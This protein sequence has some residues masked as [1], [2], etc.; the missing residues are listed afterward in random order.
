MRCNY[1]LQ[2]STRLKIDWSKIYRSDTQ[3]VLITNDSCITK[4]K[5]N[6]KKYF[7]RIITTNDLSVHNLFTLISNDIANNNINKDAIRISTID[8]FLVETTALLLDKFGIDGI[9]I[10]QSRSF[11][12]KICMKEKLS[13]TSIKIPK[14]HVFSFNEY[15]KRKNDYVDEIIQRVGFPCFSKPINSAGSYKTTKIN[16]K[17]ELNNW[18][19][20]VDTNLI[21]EIDEFI[22]GELY[23]CDSIIQNGKITNVFVSKKLNPNF[24]FL[25]GR[26]VGNITVKDKLSIIED[27]KIFN[28]VVLEALNKPNGVIH[29]ELFKLYN[30][31]LVFLEIASRPPGCMNNE[32]YEKSYSINL[33]EEHVSIQFE[34]STIKS[35]DRSTHAFWIWF[36]IK[37]GKIKSLKLPDI[38]SKYENYWKYNIGDRLEKSVILTERLGGILVY[39]DNYDELLKDFERFKDHNCLEIEEE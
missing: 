6:S 8:E 24:E 27:I 16:N 13:N 37:D 2:E 26:N 22:D 31:E 32:M 23:H 15:K 20:T 33:Q 30:N 21:F 9:T 4:L 36:P 3:I 28:Q 12:D 14:Y 35:V 39:N 19:N 7:A 17:E 18:I 5:Q 11:T 34:Q 25:K 38:N 29:L 1:L 10:E